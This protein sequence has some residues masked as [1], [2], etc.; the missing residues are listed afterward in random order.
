[1][2]LFLLQREKTN[3]SKREDRE[4]AIAAVIATQRE[5]KLIQS[6]GG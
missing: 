3:Y 6:T 5:D 4:V 1:L 2:P